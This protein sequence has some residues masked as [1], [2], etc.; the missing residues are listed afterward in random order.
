MKQNKAA[1]RFLHKK[2]S[3]A[4]I[5]ST[6]ILAM[7]LTAGTCGTFA[8]FTYATRARV[9]YEGVSI[10]TGSLQAGFMPGIELTNYT[11]YDLS[12]EVLE[13]GEVIYWANNHEI[14]PVTL[15]YILSSLGYATTEMNPVSSGSYHFGDSDFSLY[16][17]PVRAGDVM[18]GPARKESYIY[19][20]LVFR[21]ESDIEPGVYLPDIDI[22]LPKANVFSGTKIHK[23]IRIH[24]ESQEKIHL[25]NPTN[26][27]GGST[28]VGG[29]LDLNKDGYFDTYEEN[30]AVYEHMYGEFKTGK[31]HKDLPE[32]HDSD[33]PE[34]ERTTF[35]AR[36]KQGTYA[37]DTIKSIPET[38]D[39]EGM[40]NFK[41]YI[42]PIC[43]T[44][45]ETHNY[46]YVDFT[47]FIEGW[48]LSVIEAEKGN[49]FNMELKFGVE[50]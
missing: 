21:Y 22:Y 10:G 9:E 2:N 1:K 39:F 36:H 45:I 29:V 25:I 44:N 34:S 38:A 50:L 20:P 30:N 46:A 47:A 40:M 18:P 37:I 3:F 7:S 35:V 16:G 28:K 33:V 49:P 5:I 24:T 48:D 12:R 31:I 8:W 15:D 32:E 11:N 27:L 43:T 13:T 17:A 26:D 41:N 42:T 4:V 6:S 23:S 19:L 14:T